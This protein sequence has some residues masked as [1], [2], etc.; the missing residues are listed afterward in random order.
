M[1]MEINVLVL[2]V[3]NYLLVAKVTTGLRTKIF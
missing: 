2:I 1:H 3:L